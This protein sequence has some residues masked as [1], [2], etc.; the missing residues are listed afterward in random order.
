MTA[1]N[2]KVLF[3]FNFEVEFTLLLLTFPTIQALGFAEL[4]FHSVNVYRNFRFMQICLWWFCFFYQKLSFCLVTIPSHKYWN[5]TIFTQ[6]WFLID[7]LPKYGSVYPSCPTCRQTQ[8]ECCTS[9]FC[10]LTW[11]KMLWWGCG[12]EFPIFSFSLVSHL[13]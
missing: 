2:K 7:S 6:Q 4:K 5:I 3:N 11:G 12:H 10:S 1:Q 13:S 9:R 8:P